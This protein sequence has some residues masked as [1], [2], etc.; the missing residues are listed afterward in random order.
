MGEKDGEKKKWDWKPKHLLVVAF[1]LVLL[2]KLLG[3]GEDPQA[4]FMKQQAGGC[5]VCLIAAMLLVPSALVGG[6]YFANKKGMINL[7]FGNDSASPESN[8]NADEKDLEIPPEKANSKTRQ[9]AIVDQQAPH[10]SDEI[11]IWIWVAA[12]VLI[13]VVFCCLGA[14]FFMFQ[15][16]ES[17]SIERDIEEGF[18]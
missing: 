1:V 6:A 13:L 11:P 9:P 5:K 14:M 10:Q 12:A 18:A 16:D 3:G 7:P 17:D 15:D 8:V 4:S 2:A